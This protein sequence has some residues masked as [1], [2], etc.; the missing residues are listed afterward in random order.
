[1]LATSNRFMAASSRAVAG[2]SSKPIA[3]MRSAPWPTRA[4]TLI[5]QPPVSTASRYS[6]NV[7][8]VTSGTSK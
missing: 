4:A 7:R 1:M 3:A 5:A 2:R 8:Q 6:P